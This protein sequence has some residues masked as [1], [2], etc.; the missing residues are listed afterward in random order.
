MALADKKTTAPALPAPAREYDQQW[1]GQ[2]TNVLRIYFRQ[3]DEAL[4]AIIA[5][6]T[7]S[8]K[9]YTNATGDYTLRTVDY[10]VEYTG[11]TYTVTL[12]SAV[13]LQGQEFEVK[14]SGTGAITVDTYGTETMDDSLTKIVGQ[15]DGMKVMSNG[16][17]WIIV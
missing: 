6:S 2:L 9:A 12:P 17:N 10:L 13:G 14:N 7:V 8:R 3:L 4:R 15:Y 11:G 16:T 1:F 5:A